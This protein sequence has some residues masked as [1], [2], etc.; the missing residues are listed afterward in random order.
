MIGCA[1]TK[2]KPYD[3]LYPKNLFLGEVVD[4]VGTKKG[5]DAA[6]NMARLS[7]LH[8]GRQSSRL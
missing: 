2:R 1:R 8:N 4:K 5:N 7:G 6:K 3:Q